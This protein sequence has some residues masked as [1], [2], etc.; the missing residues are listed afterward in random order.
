MRSLTGVVAA[1]DVFVFASSLA[2]AA[3]LAVADQTTTD[4]LYNGDDAM[5]LVKGGVTL[6]VIGQIGFDP[7]TE[8]GTGLVSTA[9]NTLVR[10]STVCAGDPIGSDAFDPALEWDGYAID[11]FTYL[12]SH[13]ASCDTAPAVFST[14]PADGAKSVALDAPID[15]TFSELVAVT[16]DWFDISC[17]LSV[18][19]HRRSRPMQT[20]CTR[21]RRMRPL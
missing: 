19:T 16:G 8:W 7:G 20:R 18:R 14:A 2:G 5:E 12:G 10:K 17:S 11:T 4:G 15:I 3:I 9:D 13:S 21:S 1:G 6:D